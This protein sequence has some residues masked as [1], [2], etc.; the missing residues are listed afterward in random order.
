MLSDAQIE[1]FH[2]T[3]FLVVDNVL[4]EAQLARIKAEYK[5]I[6]DGLCADWGIESGDFAETLTRAYHQ[7]FDWFQPMDI[8]L[9]G[10]RIEADTPMHFGPAVFDMVTAPRL[11][12][13]VECLIGSEITSNPIQH[14]RI[15]PPERDLRAD[16]IRAHVGGT[17]WHQDRAVALEEADQTDMV[18]VWLAIT[19]AT[20]ENG[21]LQT[22]Q[23]ADSLLPHCPQVQTSIAPGF[24]DPD[25]AVPLPVRAGGAVLFHP[26]TPHASL[27]NVSDGIRWSFDL[28]YNRT[29]QPTG[30]AHF[31]EFVARS[32]AAPETEL[33]DWRTWR[34]MWETAR[35]K[36]AKEPH[37]DLHRWDADAPVCA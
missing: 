17:A 26:M 13:M 36:L 20:V 21:C 27:P 28:R 2:A 6:L 15:K 4:D 23:K 1:A 8:S 12:D 3:G 31:P 18:T 9:P 19:D 11:L 29:G 32:R 14:V 22:I 37:I 25:R 24:V 30:R 33:K 16:E 5:G 35:A 34:T 10:D 7:G